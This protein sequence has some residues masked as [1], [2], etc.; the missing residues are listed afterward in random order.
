MGQSLN[1]YAAGAHPTILLMVG[2]PSA[3]IQVVSTSSPHGQGLPSFHRSSAPP[4]HW[5]EC[6]WEA[7]SMTLLSTS[8]AA[9]L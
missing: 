3:Y 5:C 6:K 4:A 8:A 2:L 7:L 1:A 9:A